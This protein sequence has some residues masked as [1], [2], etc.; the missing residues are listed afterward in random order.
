MKTE[1]FCIR[2]QHMVLAETDFAGRYFHMETVRVNNS[3]DPG[4]R[5]DL[6]TCEFQE[7]YAACPPP[8]FDLEAYIEQNGEPPEILCGSLEA[9]EIYTV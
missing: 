1:L 7:G 4:D 3:P 9:E 2:H 8:V 6:E 5:Y